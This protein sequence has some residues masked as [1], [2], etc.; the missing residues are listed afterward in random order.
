MFRELYEHAF[1]VNGA[2]RDNPRCLSGSGVA[3]VDLR[4]WDCLNGFVYAQ[5]GKRLQGSHSTI[6]DLHWGS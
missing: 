6:K 4:L 2:V 1:H 3:I 5:I